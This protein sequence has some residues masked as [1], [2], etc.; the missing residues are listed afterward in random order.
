MKTYSASRR[1]AASSS[2]AWQ[3]LANLDTWLPTLKTVEKVEYSGDVFFTAG[4]TYRVHTP[5]GVV[6]SA[7]LTE[8]D[9]TRL[10]VRIDAHAGVLRSQLVCEIRPDGNGCII[11][12]TQSYPGLIGWIF[13]Q[14]FNRREAEETHLY[15]DEWERAAQQ[16]LDAHE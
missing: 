8:I 5:E 15:L 7:T 11:T 9:Q 16:R 6:M 12:R 4:N 13:T 10:H 2:A 3:A 1:I 14:F